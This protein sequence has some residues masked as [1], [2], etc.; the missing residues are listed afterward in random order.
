MAWIHQRGVVGGGTRVKKQLLLAALAGGSAIA[1]QRVARRYRLDR[2]AA[3]ARV[4]A[5]ARTAVITRFGAVEYAERGSG[6]PLLAIHGFFGGCDEALLSVRGLAA[7]RRVIAPSRFGYLGSSMPAGASVAGQ[8]DAFA[9]LLDALGI[10]RLDVAAISSGA[11]SALQFALR[12]PDRVKHL[13]VISGN[14]PGSATAVAPPQA[15]RLVYRDVPMWALKVFARPVLLSQ[16]GVP[17]G[18]PFAAGDQRI[19]SDLIDSFFPV[20]L[21]TEGVAFDAFIAD[22]DVNNYQLE[23]L[24]APTLIVHAQ[25][26]PLVSYEAAQRA[27]ARI[28][29]AR[30]VSMK[31]GHLL[32][33]NR[34]AVGREVV[35]FL[36]DRGAP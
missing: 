31:G 36:A 17:E 1:G 13:A 18:F 23:A 29:R 25:D 24:T 21:K 3:Y 5:V 22:P 30:L 9:A 6:K 16:I 34:E 35:T 32:L 4:A 20:A 28:P 11:T 14:M 27:A 19:V 10:D 15:A 26:D 12:H 2:E 33:G 8:A 7:S